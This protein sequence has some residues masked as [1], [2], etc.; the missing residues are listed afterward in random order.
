MQTTPPR[1]RFP[2]EYPPAPAPPSVLSAQV[3]AHS[4]PGQRRASLT[5]VSLLAAG[6]VVVGILLGG[7]VSAEDGLTAARDALA[8]G[9]A[10]RAVALDESI[11]GRSGFLMLFDPG[12]AASASA[13]AQT[14]RIAW[15]RQLAA[16]GDVSGAIAALSEVGLPSLASDAA[17]VR[18]Q[19]L[20]TAAGDATKK[21]QPSVA[22]QWLDQAGTD[23]PP[24]MI[25]TI[26][27]M[28]AADEVAA[29]AQLLAAG[30][31][32]DAL[33][34]LDAA[35]TDGAAAAAA[36]LYPSALLAAAR[37]RLAALEYQG[38]A[39]DLGRLVTIAPRSSAAQTARSLLR[40]PQAVSG[41][42]VD[43]TGQPASG[44]V[45]LGTHYSVLSGGYSTTG[46]FYYGTADAA[47]D[48]SVAG[49]PV[50]GP[51]VLEYYRNGSWMTL[52]DPRTDQ[53]ANP[54]TVTPL[55]PVDLTFIILPG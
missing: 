51:Y 31:A 11:A 50:G 12:A 42:L 22:L 6:A 30:R 44:R 8:G 45:R 10:G 48:F 21:T 38:A 40:A 36:P 32:V 17:T 13:A 15:A 43:A 7:R 46:P 52:V 2:T 19:I 33:P 9:N 23:A 41:T 18:T 49:V 35:S 54:V 29:A 14:A 3:A 27:T 25:H 47:G 4:A 37:A 26:V 20:I 5:T 28:R 16:D 39:A 53:P 1:A 24:A 55:T 34:L